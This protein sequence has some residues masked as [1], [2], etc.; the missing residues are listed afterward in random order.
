MKYTKQLHVLLEPKSSSSRLSKSI[1][2]IIQ[3]LIIIN[4]V[5]IIL[6]SFKQLDGYN[7]W[8]DIIE[9]ISVIIFTIEYVLRLLT[10]RYKFPN[11]VSVLAIIKYIKTPMA[12]IDLLAILPFYLPFFF[13]F[14]L[15]FMR[16]LRLTRTLRIL[17]LNRYSKSL[18]ILGKVL[19]KKK[20][21]LIVTLFVTLV[22]IIF[23]S[24]LM[25]YLESEEQSEQFPNI[26]A[27][28]WWAIA[29]LTTVGYGDVYPVTVLGKIF[30]AIV[31]LLGIGLVAIPTGIISSGFVEEVQTN[32]KRRTMKLNS[33]NLIN[34]Q[35]KKKNRKNKGVNN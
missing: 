33:S 1:D 8:F 32:Q 2:I 25:Y 27:S 23:A 30:S 26:I 7:I 15:R 14:D 19:N 3:S 13:P 35:R 12:V 5:A 22:L 31:A 21:D 9:L 20:G 28:A 17:K 11:T 34:K 6:S 10:A 16:V 18:Q 29:T 4:V 24:S